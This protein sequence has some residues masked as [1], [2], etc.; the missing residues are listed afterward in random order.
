[1]Q[2]HF[3]CRHDINDYPASQHSQRIRQRKGA[4]SHGSDDFFCRRTKPL[5]LPEKQVSRVTFLLPDCLPMQ[6]A[7]RIIAVHFPPPHSLQQ[8]AI[9]DR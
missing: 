9:N 5:L 6:L 1:M 3:S 8:D 2:S 4:L 7:D